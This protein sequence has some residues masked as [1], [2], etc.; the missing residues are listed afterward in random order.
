MSRRYAYVGPAEIRDA[1]RDHPS[2]AH[3]TDATTLARWLAAAEPGALATFVVSLDGVLCLADRHSEHVA[4]A[5]GAD[6][7][8][9]GEIGFEDGEVVFV[10]NLSTGYCPEPA[11]WT[12]IAA[13]LDRLGV[14]RPDTLSAAFDY[15][16]CSTCGQRNVVKDGWWVC[17][18][19]EAQLPE[20]W[21]FA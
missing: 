21:N 17:A 9:A 14:D 4:C 6:V 11:C 2:G 3:V 18:V 10:S 19:C 12:A 1:V 7:L 20:T 8:G 5:G 15:R 13:A 16:K